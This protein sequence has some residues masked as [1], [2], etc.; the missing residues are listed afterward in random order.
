M[1]LVWLQ[2]PISRKTEALYSFTKHI[3]KVH[4]ARKTMS[5]A[6]FVYRV[7]DQ[8]AY[9]QVIL[10]ELRSIKSQ[11]VW[12]QEDQVP[13]LSVV[14]LQLGVFPVID[15][16]P[17]FPSLVV[18][19]QPKIMISYHLTSCG[20]LTWERFAGAL[21]GPWWPAPPPRDRRSSMPFLCAVCLTPPA[22]KF[23]SSGGRCLLLHFK[24]RWIE[25]CHGLYAKQDGRIT[26]AKRLIPKY[27]HCR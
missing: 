20:N 18:P 14:D 19:A 2:V 1:K 10:Y 26:N 8:K 3:V 25:I 11:S 16:S 24:P 22:S 4:D 5:Y 12:Q 23:I 17:I 7:N 15:H 6:Y 21:P 13:V 27:R 9:P